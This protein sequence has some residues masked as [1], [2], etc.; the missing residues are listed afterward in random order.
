MNILLT[1]LGWLAWNIGLFSFEK[2]KADDKGEV[3]DV[4][5]YVRCYWDN[6]L[7]SAIFIPILI[8]V[9]IKQLGLEALPI[10][11]AAHMKWNDLYYLGAGCAAEA[12]KYFTQRIIK[13]F[14]SQ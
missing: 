6:W 7:F 14:S 13:K 11:D 3:F 8:I 9:G 12:A 1:V 4:R 10:D 2:D 5:K